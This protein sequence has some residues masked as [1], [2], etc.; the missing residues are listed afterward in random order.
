[1]GYKDMEE[2]MGPYECDCPA[3]ILDLLT[4]TDRDY[5]LH[6]RARCSENIAARGAKAAQPGHAP[7]QRIVCDERFG[8]TG[9]C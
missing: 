5:A 2:S 7:G 4:P 9:C 8:F 6:W 1:M 3:L